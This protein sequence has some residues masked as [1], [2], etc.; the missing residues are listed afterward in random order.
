[1]AAI[2]FVRIKSDTPFETLEPR[3]YERLT[4]FRDVP[5]LIQA[6]WDAQARTVTILYRR[7]RGG[8]V[9]IAT[10][11]IRLNQQGLGIQGTALHGAALTR[12]Q[13]S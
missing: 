5:G 9:R 6:L 7:E 2:L 10:E 11:I 3:M 1:M 13:A 8:G 12:D 4:R